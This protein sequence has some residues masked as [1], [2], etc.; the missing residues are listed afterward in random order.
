[1][2]AQN[3]PL[4]FLVFEVVILCIVLVM[5]HLVLIRT[6]RLEESYMAFAEDMSVRG[7]VTKIAPLDSESVTIAYWESGDWT[8]YH[9]VD[10][11]M[12]QQGYAA[13]YE[14]LRFDVPY[15]HPD[16]DF[17]IQNQVN[18]VLAGK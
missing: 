1:M 16:A 4:M 5:G 17:Y 2:A 13:D 14:V 8:R 7:V 11:Y 3:V 9:S 6:R 15:S 10:M 12:A 18:R